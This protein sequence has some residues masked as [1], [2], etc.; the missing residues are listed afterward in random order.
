MF[1]NRNIILGVTGSIAAYKAVEL[2]RKLTLEGAAVDV[3]MSEAATEFVTPLTFRSITHRPVVVKMFDPASEF[4]IEHVSLAKRA[5]IVV[6][7]PATANVIAKLAGGL[8]NDILCCTVLA[9]RAPVLIAPA[10]E[11]NMYHNQITQD[12]LS[13]LRT[14]GFTI[15]DPTYG[16]LASGDVGMGRLAEIDQILDVIRQVLA[17][18]HDLAGKHIVVTAG[19]TQ[20]PID[21]VRHIGNRSSGKMGYAIAEAARDRGAD[22]TLISAPTA[23]LTPAG[24]KIVQVQTALQMREAVLKTTPKTDVLIM[25][26]A[27][28]DYRPAKLSQ[29]KIKGGAPSLTL[30]LTPNPDIISGVTGQLIKVGFAAESENLIENARKK[31]E[32]KH[33]DL[34]VANNITAADSGFDVDANRVT[35]IDK[36]GALEELPLLPKS[37][38]ANKILDRV[39]ALLS[40]SGKPRRKRK[41]S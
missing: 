15:I 14:R 29:S 7:A 36:N 6:I 11:V 30:E 34:I 17:R 4:S 33:L 13:K 16:T 23:I 5:D 8:A 2:A 9:T 40:E 28:A 26:A 22:V 32:R 18:S 31:L 37:E 1:A 41:P 27:V 25:A 12:N 10:M 39:A 20:E 24:M 21:P 38:V 3:V 35:L 19:G